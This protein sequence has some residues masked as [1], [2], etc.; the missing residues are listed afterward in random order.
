[1]ESVSQ[2]EGLRFVLEAVDLETFDG[3]VSDMK[4]ALERV[5][6]TAV[7]EFRATLAQMRK[8]ASDTYPPS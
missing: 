8:R 2:R 5:K 7:D 3:R 4:A 6:G 1:M